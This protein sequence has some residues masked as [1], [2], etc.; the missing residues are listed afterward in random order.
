MPLSDRTHFAIT[1]TQIIAVC[2]LLCLIFF[3]SHTWDRQRVAGAVLV[4]IG[5]A[6]IAVARFQLGKSF[7]IKPEARQLVTHGIYSK[8]RNP[9][10]VFGSIMIA[11]FALFAH[12]PVLWL[13]FIFV[14]VMQTFR[15]HREAQV[16]EAAFGDDYRQYRRQT[17]F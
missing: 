8:I 12:R 6:G 2:A 5:I 1:A 14:V 4:L 16:L 15:A 9:I 10:Y 7:A 3:A 17:W 11:G 13:L